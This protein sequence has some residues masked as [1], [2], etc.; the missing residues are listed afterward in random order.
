MEE[1]FEYEE[2]PTTALLNLI[3]NDAPLFSPELAAEAYQ[4]VMSNV[5][6]R[7][8]LAHG[9]TEAYNLT[10]RMASTSYAGP[11]GVYLMGQDQGQIAGRRDLIGRLCSLMTAEDLPDPRPVVK[12]HKPRTSDTRPPVRRAKAKTPAKKRK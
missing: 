12:K 1:E 11:D 9:L 5:A 6:I 4:I 7:A 3:A 8:M 10:A 2:T